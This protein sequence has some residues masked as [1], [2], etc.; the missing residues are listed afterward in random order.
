LLAVP[1]LFVT[2]LVLGPLLESYR[3]IAAAIDLIGAFGLNVLVFAWC[4]A[5]GEERGYTF[6]RFFTY[7]VVVFGIKAMV[8]YIFRS[9]GFVQGMVS[10]GW[11]LMYLICAIV[12]SVIV[13]VLIMIPL[14]ITGLIGIEPPPR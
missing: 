7:A 1:I 10:L 14:I 11:F 5:D 3:A 8:Y 13:G 12:A 9:R 4:R 6:H 2:V